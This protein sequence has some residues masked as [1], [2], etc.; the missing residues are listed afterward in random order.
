LHTGVELHSSTAS[1]QTGECLGRGLPFGVRRRVPMKSGR[2][3]RFR[4]HVHRMRMHRHEPKRR[5]RP[6]PVGACGTCRR[7]PKAS[8]FRGAPPNWRMSRHRLA[9][10]SSLPHFLAL[11]SLAPRPL[12]PQR[13]TSFLLFVRR[14]PPHT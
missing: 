14:P 12:R 2:P 8:A 11:A 5:G 7:T 1:R 4:L 3:R 9:L 6:C 13:E 10:W